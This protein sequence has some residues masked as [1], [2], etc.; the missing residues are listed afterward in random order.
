MHGSFAAALVMAALLARGANGTV[1]RG[2]SVLSQPS[3]DAH[4]RLYQLADFGMLRESAARSF[5]THWL[6]RAM[7]ARL[8]QR[9][10]LKSAKRVKNVQIN[11]IMKLNSQIHLSTSDP[12]N[13]NSPNCRSEFCIFFCP[14]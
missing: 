9:A 6:P 2:V 14:F 13:D 3:F 4:S 11:M 1:M 12:S 7:M 8:G 5:G 10:S